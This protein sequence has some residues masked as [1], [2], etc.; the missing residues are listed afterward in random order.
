MPLA[1]TP[2]GKGCAAKNAAVVTVSAPRPLKKCVTVRHTQ[3]QLCTTR[4]GT[5]SFLPSFFS[6]FLPFPQRHTQ[7]QRSGARMCHGECLYVTCSRVSKVV[8]QLPPSVA[9]FLRSLLR[10]LVCP[11]VRH[12]APLVYVRALA[13]WHR[14]LLSGHSAFREGRRGELGLLHG[15]LYRVRCVVDLLV[16]TE[17]LQGHRRRWY[18]SIRRRGLYRIFL[19]YFSFL[20]PL[21]VDEVSAP[22]TQLK[23]WLLESTRLCAGTVKIML[24]LSVVLVLVCRLYSCALASPRWRAGRPRYSKC[25]ELAFRSNSVVSDSRKAPI[26]SSLGNELAFRNNSVVSASGGTDSQFSV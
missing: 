19:S 6:F 8:L 12:R 11:S 13:E 15:W 3:T 14:C 24:S 25:N 10:A 26:V 1:V 9:L 18:G 16:W 23:W 5:P 17:T 21:P 4:T 20:Y 7:A 22:R 2:L